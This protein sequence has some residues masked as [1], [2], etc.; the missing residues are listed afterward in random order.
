[1][2][3][4]LTLLAALAVGFSACKKVTQ[5]FSGSKVLTANNLLAGYTETYTYNDD[6]N[7]VTVQR[8]PG[9]RT[10]YTYS[11]DTVLMQEY[12]G[13]VLV[14][15]MRY[16]LNGDA[17]ADSSYGL[18]QAQNN[19]YTYAYDGNGQLT[20]LKAYAFGAYS[21]T[22][23]YTV[24]NKNVTVA[25]TTQANGTNSSVYYAFVNTVTNTIGNQNFGRGFLGIGNLNAPVT[26]V[27]INSNGDTTDVVQ[28]KYGVSNSNIVSMVSYNKQGVL[29]DSM[30]YT[31]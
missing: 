27:N 6:G 29:V 14:S 19:S 31:Y 25:Y 11:G 9:N 21:S 3:Y 24:G 7:L 10:D 28:Y 2:K 5:T 15:G 4:I 26:R 20:Q 13:P 30:T 23:D 8:T 1:M 17:Y 16:F 18:V 12:N 22:T